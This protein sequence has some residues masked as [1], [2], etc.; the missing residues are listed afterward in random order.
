MTTPSP[1]TTDWVPIWSLGSG[2]YQ[3]VVPA[4]CAYAS[5]SISISNNAQTTIA[6]D[7]ERFDTDAIHDNITNN[8]R[9]TC[10]TAG[11]YLVVA[12]IEFVPNT[13]NQR[14]LTVNLNTNTTIAVA[15]SQG[16]AGGN[17]PLTATTIIDLVVGDFI[18]AVAY[19]N[20]GGALNVVYAPFRTPQ[21]EMT[22]IGPGIV[23][24]GVQNLSGT[25]A[26]RPAIGTVPQGT[27]YFATDTLGTFLSDG[28]QWLL[29]QQRAPVITS[30]TMSAAPFM[31]PYDGQEI[32]LVDSVT[33][34]TY[35]WRFRYNAQ[36]TSAYKWEFIGGPPMAAYE[37]TAVQITAW[38][39]LGP[40]MTIPRR[41]VYICSGQGNA[42]CISAASV[43]ISLRWAT[44]PGGVVLGDSSGVD[45]TLALQNFAFP[46]LYEQVLTIDPAAN[47]LLQWNP[48]TGNDYSRQRQYRVT[49]VR[50]I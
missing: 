17:T 32:I 33:A 37:V 22:Y 26:A 4:C 10:K 20:S 12:T 2:S 23:G 15:V 44:Y 1:A 14:Q 29:V 40:V 8:S 28:L 50:V 46:V 39:A 7:G 42:Y 43:Y 47:V 3:S 13:T 6:F 5:A 36:S 34:P 9:L 35:D 31:T 19:Q 38:L 18:E 11:K 27:T 16:L 24:Q 21:L 25:F 41:G 48:T 30:A 45:Y 49:P